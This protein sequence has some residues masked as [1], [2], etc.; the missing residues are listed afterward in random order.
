MGKGE[1]ADILSKREREREREREEE[2]EEEEE[3]TFET[4]KGVRLVGQVKK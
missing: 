2:E 1:S 3:E 4:K